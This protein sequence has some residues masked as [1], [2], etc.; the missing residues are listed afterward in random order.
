MTLYMGGRQI[1]EMSQ[2]V[3]IREEDNKSNKQV[4]AKVLIIQMSL[5]VLY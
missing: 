3:H 4:I 1:F 5:L 2:K